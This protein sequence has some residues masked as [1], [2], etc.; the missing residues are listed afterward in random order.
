MISRGRTA[1][2]GVAVLGLIIA[3]CSTGEDAGMGGT[4]ASA[5]PSPTISDVQRAEA[6]LSTSAELP[7]APPGTIVDAGLG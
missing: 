7:P 1:A 6:A 4:A 3:G 5:S 2:L